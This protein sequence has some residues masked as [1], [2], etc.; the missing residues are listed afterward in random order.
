MKKPI[1]IIIGVIKNKN[2]YLMTKRKSP[3]KEWN[4]WQFPGG[5]INFGESLEMALKR[6]IKEETNLDV[7]KLVFTQKIFEVVRK[8]EKW[9]GLLIVYL[10]LIKKT[11][12]IILNNEASDFD[13]FTYQEILSLDCLKGT[14]EIIKYIQ[15]NFL[16]ASLNNKLS[17]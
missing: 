7:K 15:N 8:K 6:E 1:P 9:H 14:K 10:C 13:W 12:K 11:Q 5:G 4:K 2:R 3:K 17:G 16:D